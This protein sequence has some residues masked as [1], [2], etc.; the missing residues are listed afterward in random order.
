M[1]KSVSHYVGGPLQ[2]DASSGGDQTTASN[3]PSPQRHRWE[4]VTQ[5]SNFP[6]KNKIKYFKVFKKIANE[7][8]PSIVLLPIFLLHKL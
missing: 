7:W 6:K 8:E 1:L 4:C 3:A 2:N 5:S